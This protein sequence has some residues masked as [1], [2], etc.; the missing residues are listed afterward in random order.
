[1][2][3]GPL[4]YRYRSVAV[5]VRLMCVSRL[6]SGRCLTC[7]DFTAATEAAA[8][9]KATGCGWEVSRCGKAARCHACAMEGRPFGVTGVE[10][11]TVSPASAFDLL[12]PEDQSPADPPR[13][14]AA[15]RGRSKSARA[16]RRG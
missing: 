6:R 10:P 13:P 4:V 16:G 15:G 3:S 1:M 14:P 11:T 5:T 8:L 12:H 9:G 2:P 7:L